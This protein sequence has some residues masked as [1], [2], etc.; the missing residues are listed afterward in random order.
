M[1]AK[2]TT[3]RK[4]ARK[5][6]LGLKQVRRSDSVSVKKG[7][8]K[9]APL[10]ERTWADDLFGSAVFSAHELAGDDRLRGLV[11]RARTKVAGTSA[12]RA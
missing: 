1:K 12:R 10:S 11:E 2:A 5:S 7:G 6:G 9:K 8:A 3:P 4:R